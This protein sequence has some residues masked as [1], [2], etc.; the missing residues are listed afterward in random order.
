MTTGR[1]NQIT[2]P[3]NKK[4]AFGREAGSSSGGRAEAGWEAGHDAPPGVH[5]HAQALAKTPRLLEGGGSQ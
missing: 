5:C 4:L 3:R 1:I 2:G